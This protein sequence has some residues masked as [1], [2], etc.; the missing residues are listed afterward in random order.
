[1]LSLFLAT[2]RLFCG[3]LIVHNVDRLVA[4]NVAGIIDRTL[5]RGRDAD[6]DVQVQVYVQARY[7]EVVYHSAFATDRLVTDHR[8]RS[9]CRSHQGLLMFREM[10]Q[11]GLKDHL[12][13]LIT[14]LKRGTNAWCTTHADSAGLKLSGWLL[15][16]RE[17]YSF[18]TRKEVIHQ[19]GP[20]LHTLRLRQH[21]PLAQ[22]LVSEAKQ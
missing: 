3:G 15:R 22:I 17:V 14:T 9:T 21:R 12:G 5:G 18:L 2:F 19:G 7:E 11:R 6:V 8:L 10:L 1:M 13:F 16:L 4:V 20:L